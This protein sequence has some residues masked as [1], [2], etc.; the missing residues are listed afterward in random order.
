[1]NVMLR[2]PALSTSTTRVC[3]CRTARL[4]RIACTARA[5][6]SQDKL[7]ARQIAVAGGAAVLLLVSFWYSCAFDGARILVRLFTADNRPTVPA[8][9]GT[10]PP[11]G[12]AVVVFSKLDDF[13]TEVLGTCPWYLCY[14]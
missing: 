7:T 6:P 3:S 10:V 4:H 9:D 8:A 2:Q 14:T 11:I 13:E 5:A 1:M 12:N